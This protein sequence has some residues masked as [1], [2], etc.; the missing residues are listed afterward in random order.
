MCLYSLQV[1]CGVAESHQMALL[2]HWDGLQGLEVPLPAVIQ[3]YV[4]HGGLVWKAYVA[5]D[6][7]GDMR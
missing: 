7:V 3:E 5:G 6:K 1:A 4:D 2:L